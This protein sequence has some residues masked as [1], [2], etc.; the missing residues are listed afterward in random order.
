MKE[1]NKVILVE[2]NPIIERWLAVISI[3]IPLA[4]LVSFS[5][6]GILSYFALIYGFGMIPILELFLPPF[7]RNTPVLYREYE[8]RESFFFIQ[9]GIL[10]VNALSHLIFCLYFI[11]HINLDSGIFTWLGHVATMG[12]SMGVLGIN[13]AHELG[14]RKE[15]SY[16]LLGQVLLATSLYL[17]FFIE[18]NKGHHRQ[19]STKEDPASARKNESVYTFAFRSIWG[20]WQ[21]A[22]KLDSS[23]MK[24]FLSL[25]ILMLC[26]IVG[27]FGMT[28]FISF[29]LAAIIGIA[30]L[31]TVNYIEHYGLT[32]KINPSGR[33]EKV[34]P[35][36]SW[37]SDHFF[38][39][40][41]LF[42]LSRHSDHH[43]YANRPFPLLKHHDESP[44]L[45]T[46]YP[47]MMIL[48]LFP[49]LWFKVMNPRLP[50]DL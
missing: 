23:L 32:R 44:Q 35:V 12:L 8:N 37:N 38:S 17:H 36:H 39:R 49:S 22:W 10:F 24:R 3:T 6:Q 47:G 16:Q 29:L 20:Q 43:A 7:S 40:G 21:S 19:V 27:F 14:H 46:G 28:T 15:K 42:N 34:T 5:S 9:E 2:E 33:Y 26:V 30:L 18:H 50:A 31:E 48:A 13:V 41:I 11:F 1:N 4:I 25:E 45:P